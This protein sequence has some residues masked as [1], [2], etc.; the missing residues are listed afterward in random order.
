MILAGVIAAKN[1]LFV[2]HL[3]VLSNNNIIYPSIGRYLFVN[4]VNI[5]TLNCRNVVI[6]K[7]K[8]QKSK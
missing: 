6:E 5:Y 4:P 8:N 3:N 1:K 7:S 2:L